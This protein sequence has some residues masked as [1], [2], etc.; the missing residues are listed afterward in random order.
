MPNI[1]KQVHN[2]I[3]ISIWYYFQMSDIYRYPNDP[4]DEKAAIKA[5]TETLSARSSW[6]GV[7]NS[8]Q[9]CLK[10]KTKYASETWTDGKWQN[11]WWIFDE[12]RV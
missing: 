2:W 11:Q 12:E 5:E 9:H 4:E 10:V 1:K 8:T 7:A 6:I 3:T